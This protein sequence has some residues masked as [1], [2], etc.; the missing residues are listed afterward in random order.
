MHMEIGMTCAPGFCDGVMPILNKSA[1]AARTRRTGTPVAVWSL[2]SQMV[3]RRRP[4][5]ALLVD[6]G[7]ASLRLVQDVQIAQLGL[8]HAI[9]IAPGPLPVGERLLLEIPVA[10]HV[11][12]CTVLVRVVDN[13]IVL[14]DGLFRRRVRLSILHQAPRG[15]RFEGVRMRR[16]GSVMGA[17][18]RR[19]PV[20]LIEASTTGCVFDSP[21]LIVEGAVGFVQMRTSIEERSEA[22]RVRRTSQT[23]D[24]VWQHRMAAEFLTLGASLASLRGRATIMTVSSLGATNH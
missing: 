8:D 4:E 18:I 9:V 15:W 21:S 2:G 12:P 23:S 16:G 1:R 19:V 13:G 17:L 6:P 14:D 24:I 7:V 22:V 10:L 11:R 3:E 20:R 5:R